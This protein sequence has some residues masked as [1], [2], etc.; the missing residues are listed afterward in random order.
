MR[1]SP[2]TSMREKRQEIGTFY[3]FKTCCD[4]IVSSDWHSFSGKLDAT[5][6]MDRQFPLKEAWFSG[7]MVRAKDI[8]GT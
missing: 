4:V 2:Y 7:S 5:L 3:E 6:G 8:M 1:V